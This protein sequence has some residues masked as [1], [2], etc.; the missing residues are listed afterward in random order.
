MSAV[1][2]ASISSEFDIFAHKP[3]QTSVLG[4][5]ETAYKPIAPGEENDLEFLI[6][7]DK[8]T[9]YGSIFNSMSGVN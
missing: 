7:G 1:E 2:V 9:T 8:K 6:P 3:L 5:I 4:T